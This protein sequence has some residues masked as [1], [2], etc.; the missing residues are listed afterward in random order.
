MV[1]ENCIKAGA[2]LINDVS[3]M[4]YDWCMADVVAKYGV[5]VI[6][7]HSKGTP[8]NMQNSPEYKNLMD[9]IFLDLNRKI[10]FA[11][12]KGIAKIKL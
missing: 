11:L 5:H 3:G 12:T 7:Q 10:G 8:E 9:E 1:A 4:T 2:V 6:L